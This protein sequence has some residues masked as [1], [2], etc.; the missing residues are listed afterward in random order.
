MFSN[1]KISHRLWL[2]SGL[3]ALLFVTAVGIGW[4]GLIDARNALK[5]VY[6]D[7]TLPLHDLGEIDGLQR[8]NYTQVLLAFQ[9]DP[10]GHLAAV[11][12]HPV[13]LHF[14][15]VAKNREQIKAVWDKYMATY[16]TEEEKK[17]VEVYLEKR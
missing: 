1:L 17:R 13:S 14:D 9:H 12:D 7:R 8:E 6:E 5:T 16:L 15:N 2:M 3:A 11:H 10:T 4:E